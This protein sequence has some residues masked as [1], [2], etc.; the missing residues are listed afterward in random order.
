MLTI[1]SATV[2][3]RLGTQPHCEAATARLEYIPSLV[4]VLML[5]QMLV[6]MPMPMLVLVLVLMLRLST[7]DSVRDVYGAPL[8]APTSLHM[9]ALG[10]VVAAGAQSQTTSAHT[11]QENNTG[12]ASWILMPCSTHNSTL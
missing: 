1:E 7:Q 4:L 11:N 6:Q 3:L 9:A 12:G 5:V 8:D 2:V 10:S